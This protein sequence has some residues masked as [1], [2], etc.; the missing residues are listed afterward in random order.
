MALPLSHIPAEVFREIRKHKWISFFT[1][2]LV[3]F[4]VLG[5]GFVWPYQYRAEVVIYVDDSNI[6]RPLM[7]GRAVT[8]EISERTSTARE[9]LQS[10]QILQELATDPELFGSAQPDQ[11]ELE[12]RITRLRDGLSVHPRGE[13]YFGIRYAST[14]Q[15]DAFRI[16]QRLGQQFIEQ[17]RDRKRAESRN[18][19]D[20]IDKQVKG[21]E[22]QLNTVEQRMKEFLSENKEGTEEEANARMAELRTKLE[23]AELDKRELETRV[24]SLMNQMQGVR[25]TLSQGQTEDA[26]RERIKSLE[27]RLDQLRLQYHDTYP[28]IVI[29]RE[30]LAE[31][32]KQRANATA[33][34][35]SASRQQSGG[36]AIPNPV[37][38][39]LGVSLSNARANL[40]SVETRIRS[41][42]ELLV[43][44][45]QRMVRIQANKAEFSEITR[46]MEVN[47]DIYD[48]LLKRR[49]KARVSMHLDVEGQGMNFRIAEAAQY[50]T[51]PNGPQFQ[52]FA[53]AGLFLGA[54]APFG[55]LAGLLQ[56]DPRVR[57][58][59][60]LED[61]IGL[62][63]LV[64]IP[65]VRTPYEKRSSRRQTLFIFI[66]VF[67]VLAGYVGIV[68]AEHMGVL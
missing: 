3:S 46:D 10:R 50:P 28:D 57:A 4:L 25:P 19:Y 13:S 33:E 65:A 38:Q 7:E 37:Y 67:T 34:S 41:L 42:Q 52:M 2:A 39:E 66:F 35:D 23:L 51:S 14:S 16:A 26:Y 18:A 63:V 40:A 20:F 15:L 5:A 49:E 29:T 60:Q 59:E 6:I 44:Q 54:L 21:Y 30:Q 36:D 11:Q 22:A 56:L 48:D 61:G 55:A 53:F 12:E 58:K 64:D 62:P 1:F 32:R 31:L 27:E 8:T 9:L 17:S 68:V 24:S 45:E 47:K 43:N